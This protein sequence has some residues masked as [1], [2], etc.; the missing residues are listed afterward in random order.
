[1]LEVPCWSHFVISLLSFD[2]F[3]ATILCC[4]ADFSIDSGILILPGI[5]FRLYRFSVKNTTAL[6]KL[7]ANKNLS[8]VFVSLWLNVSGA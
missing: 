2:V 1:M 4:T 3:T 5:K 7:V 6:L 8:T